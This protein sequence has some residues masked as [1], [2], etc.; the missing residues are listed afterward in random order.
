MLLPGDPR[1]I[2]R[3]A[4]LDDADIVLDPT[5]RLGPGVSWLRAAIVVGHLV[6]G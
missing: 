2:Y 5:A 4:G 3:A 6:L 1:P